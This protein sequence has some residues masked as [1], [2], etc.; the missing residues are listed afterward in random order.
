[1]LVLQ[2]S[3]AMDVADAEEL[4]YLTPVFAVGRIAT[5]LSPTKYRLG[6][7]YKLPLIFVSW[8]LE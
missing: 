4:G 5:A 8:M 3:I 6:Q 7:A 1:V 2:A